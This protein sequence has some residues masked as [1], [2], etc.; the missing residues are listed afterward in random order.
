MNSRNMTLIVDILILLNK[1]NKIEVCFLCLFTSDSPL[2]DDANTVDKFA[3]VLPVFCW[4]DLLEKSWT[5]TT[6]F[7]LLLLL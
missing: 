6:L 5:V 4:K 1:L 3:E 7:L 2:D